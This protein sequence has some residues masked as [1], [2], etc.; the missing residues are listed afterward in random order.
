M[1]SFESATNN[2]NTAGP[3]EEIEVNA[4]SLAS[5]QQEIESLQ[6]KLDFLQTQEGNEEAIQKIKEE[7][8][9]LTEQAIS[10]KN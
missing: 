2:A 6:T 9:N 4:P 7:L 8:F 1:N 3:R 10:T 5:L